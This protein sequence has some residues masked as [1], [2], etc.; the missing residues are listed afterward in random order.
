MITVVGSLNMDLIVNTERI[1]VEGE[2]VL[3][4]GFRQ[5]EGGKGANQ[6]VAAARLGADVAMIGAV[7]NDDYGTRLTDALAR[8]G[9]RTDTVIRSDEPTGVAV[10]II[11]GRGNNCITVASGANFTLTPADIEACD[12]LI[13]RSNVL[14]TQLETPLDTVLRACELARTHGCLT[15]L[16]P[17]PA[18]DLPDELL[19]RI[20]LLTPNETE[21]ALL[22]GRSTDTLEQCERAGRVLLERGVKTLL[23]TLGEHGSL[24]MTSERTEHIP[25]FLVAMTDSTAAGDC[26]NGALVTALERGETL[27]DAISFAMK[28]AAMAVTRRGAQPSLPTAE[29]MAGFDAWFET[30][31]L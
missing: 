15:V 19:A 12:A 22:S 21:L 7:G 18:T 25:A 8:D 4:H 20:D 2:T 29:D 23:V 3:G 17:A 31:R 26:F 1:P 28:A 5:A 6:A 30:H 9:I 14:L 13:A 10:I 27:D 24:L 16:N 11:N